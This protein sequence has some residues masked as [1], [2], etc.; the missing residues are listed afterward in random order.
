MRSEAPPVSRT[1]VPAAPPSLGLGLLLR[2]AYR[3]FLR[4]LD[5]RL[6]QHGITHAQ[7]VHLWYLREHDGASPIELSRLA[8]I[9]K[10]SSTAVLDALER[11]GIII[12]IRNQVDNRKV[13][14]R[15]TP[16]G[17]VFLETLE[18]SAADANAAACVG[19]SRDK[20][21]SLFHL[22]ETVIDNLAEDTAIPPAADLST[23]A[24][25]ARDRRGIRAR[26]KSLRTQRGKAGLARR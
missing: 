21:L 22:L 15:L 4:S 13:H 26:G 10:A 16:N 8:G 2:K 20:I 12:R 14:V 7:W 24:E 17:K 18:H 6:A 19:L 23:P 25:R 1:A 5:G 9:K 3:A 11:R